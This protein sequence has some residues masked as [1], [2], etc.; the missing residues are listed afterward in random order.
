MARYC[1]ARQ[2]VIS[3]EYSSLLLK[4]EPEFHEE[5]LRDGPCDATTTGLSNSGVTVSTLSR[6]NEAGNMRFGV[7]PVSHLAQSQK[8]SSYSSS[9]VPVAVSQRRSLNEGWNG[10]CLR[11]AMSGMREA[12]RQRP[13]VHLRRVFFS[14]GS[15]VR[16][17]C[18]Q[19]RRLP[20]RRSPPG[21]HKHV[22]LPGAAAGCR[23]LRAHHAC[24][25]GRRCCARRG[26]RSASAPRI[27]RSRTT[28]SAC[29][30]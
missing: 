2:R 22:A 25:H 11:I 6:R 21:P 14:A 15:A 9:R 17:G 16:S 23:R 5:W 1:I 27:S 26:W 8:Y 12:L 3:N 24:R 7:Q 19:A 30:R 13:A 10:C 18:G 29:P 20:A 4:S 28:P